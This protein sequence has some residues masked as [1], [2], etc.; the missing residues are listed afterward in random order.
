MGRVGPSTGSCGAAHTRALPVAGPLIAATAA[1]H[2]PVVLHDDNDFVAA[3]R[4]LTDLAER[5]VHD[6]P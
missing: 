2:G 6:T 1:H 5:N 4:V 3:S